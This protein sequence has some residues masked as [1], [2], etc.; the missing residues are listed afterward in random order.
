MKGKTDTKK[1]G[2]LQNITRMSTLNVNGLNIPSK[3][4]NYM[5]DKKVRFICMG[6]YRNSL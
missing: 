3:C 5:L 2:K 1:E 6:L 4:R